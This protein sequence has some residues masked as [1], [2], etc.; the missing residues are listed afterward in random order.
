[1]LSYSAS[2]NSTIIADEFMKFAGHVVM[3]VLIKGFGKN[4]I[5]E[6]FFFSRCILKTAKKIN[7]PVWNLYFA[8]PLSQNGF[9]N[10][11]IVNHLQ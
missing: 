9:S 6:Q 1:M 2:H 11:E 10:S 7:D 8:A 5:S 4:R 3:V